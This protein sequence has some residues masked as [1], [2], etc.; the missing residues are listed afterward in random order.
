MNESQEKPSRQPGNRNKEGLGMIP[1][2]CGMRGAGD[3]SGDT[4]DMPQT[5]V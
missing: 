3:E 2:L 4:Q 5:V 1:V